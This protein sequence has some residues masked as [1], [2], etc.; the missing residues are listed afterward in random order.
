VARSPRGPGWPARARARRRVDRPNRRRAARALRNRELPE[1]D[2]RDPEPSLLRQVHPRPQAPA[3]PGS[4]CRSAHSERVRFWVDAVLARRVSTGAQP[5]TSPCC[6]SDSDAERSRQCKASWGARPTALA[7]VG[8]ASTRG[9]RL[10][11]PVQVPHAQRLTLRS[12]PACS[13]TL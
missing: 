6:I 10:G 7:G 12:V 3:D 13:K 5:G 4:A 8:S 9:P 1:H 11:L 2:S